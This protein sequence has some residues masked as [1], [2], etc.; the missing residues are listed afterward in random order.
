MFAQLTDAGFQ[1]DFT[2]HARAILIHDFPDVEGELSDALLNVRIPVTELI[3]SGGGE[4]RVTQRLRRAL[5]AQRWQKRNVTVKKI[6]NG[7]EKESVTHE[8]DHIREY[9]DHAVALEIEWNNKDPFFDRDLETFKRLHSEG[10]FSVGV[11]VTRGQQFQEHIR[12]M[13]LRY[14]TDRG[15]K[16]F[17]DF[18]DGLD[19]RPSSKFVASVKARLGATDRSFAEVWADKFCSDKYGQATTHWRKLEARVSRGVGNPCPLLMI[20]IPDTVVDFGEVT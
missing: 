18:P 16:G 1:I 17:A 9:G 15:I 6:I 4:A 2:S 14:A 8:I 20:G 13:V 11:I 3:E 5:S 19:Y 10:A 12:A 7:I